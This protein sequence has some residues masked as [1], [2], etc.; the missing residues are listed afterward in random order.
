MTKKEFYKKLYDKGVRDPAE[1]K[2]YESRWIE[3]GNSFADGSPAPE[4]TQP[5]EKQPGLIGRAAGAVKD[6][7]VGAV[8][9]PAS[10][11]KGL[12]KGFAE[13]SRQIVAPV[14]AAGIA[15]VSALNQ[16]A[17]KLDELQYG[18]SDIPAQQPTGFRQAYSDIQQTRPQPSNDQQRR[19]MG[20][21]EFGTK[22]VMGGMLASAL[23]VTGSGW[24]PTIAKG[25]TANTPFIPKAFE[26]G[27]T[28]GALA[29]MALNTGAD[30]LMYGAGK[31]AVPLAKK[32]AKAAVSSAG[33][34]IA[35]V[36]SKMGIRG[37]K[38][39]AAD[40]LQASVVS[41]IRGMIDN[42]SGIIRLT[43]DRSKRLRDMTQDDV[44][45]LVK[46]LQAD[47]D[48]RPVIES[49]KGEMVQLR[50]SVGDLSLSEQKR[51]AKGKLA[52]PLR[53]GMMPID[54]GAPKVGTGLS[55]IGR[56]IDERHFYALSQPKKPTTPDFEALLVR[57]KQH[58]KDRAIDGPDEEVSKLL[59]KSLGEIENVGKNLAKQ[60][61]AILDANKGKTVDLGEIL[62]SWQNAVNDRL[63]AHIQWKKN[64]KGVLVADVVDAA[65]AGRTIVDPEAVGP[66]KEIAEAIKRAPAIADVQYAD[67][68]KRKIQKLAYNKKT[69]RTPDAARSLSRQLA[70]SIDEQLDAALGDSYKIGNDKMRQL[71]NLEK[72]MGS[73][74]GETVNYETGLTMHGASMM[75][76][77]MQ[78][79]QDSGIKDL[80]R[81]VYEITDGKYDLFQA[82]AYAE[83]AM[84]AVGEAKAFS[85]LETTSKIKSSPKGLA[86]MAVNLGR[87]S[88]G[89]LAT[90][91]PKNL[92]GKGDADFLLDY[93]KK[94]QKK[95]AKR[96]QPGTLGDMIR[97]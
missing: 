80:F 24:G 14:A 33:D 36:S 51:L 60:K 29:D 90:V 87:K 83:A 48:I 16:G 86:E 31:Y 44:V 2:A 5:E 45:E 67:D 6:F 12:G 97:R 4:Q 47:A 42:D 26:E 18:R 41:K 61:R 1:V 15:G 17:R 10:T 46:T 93:Y 25:A 81:Q 19:A 54:P 71:I 82:A 68:L 58:A 57:A 34:L 94:A 28:K 50:R 9:D 35:A 73:R 65:R 32:G 38:S 37:A 49:L 62:E 96:A 8:E 43:G 23:P 63:G 64:S 11:I 27:G 3:S 52:E 78:S 21:G 76:R 77:A 59:V 56:G 88:A 69:G 75:K 66:I 92:T 85:L 7:A 53:E 13:A 30:A 20:V 55:A 79:G 84:K 22:A 39:Q 70:H 91:N 95:A 89:R 40:A 72:H 74:L